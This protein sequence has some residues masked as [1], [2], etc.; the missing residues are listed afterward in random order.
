MDTRLKQIAYKKDNNEKKQTV[1]IDQHIFQFNQFFANNDFKQALRESYKIADASAHLLKTDNDLVHKLIGVACKNAN[2]DDAAHH[3]IALLLFTRCLQTIDPSVTSGISQIYFAQ[4]SLYTK[5]D[6]SFEAKT[7]M[8]NM[9]KITEG[10]LKFVTGE[11]FVE[12]LF[13]IINYFFNN[14]FHDTAN[15]LFLLATKALDDKN[16]LF[17]R[18]PFSLFFHWFLHNEVNYQSFIPFLSTTIN[19]LIPNHSDIAYHLLIRAIELSNGKDCDDLLESI[20]VQAW[21]VLFGK[22]YTDKERINR[23]NELYSISPNEYMQALAYQINNGALMF[24]AYDLKPD[25]QFI[26]S[27][28]KK[29]ADPFITFTDKTV[30][31][32]KTSEVSALSCAIYRGHSSLVTRFFKELKKDDNFKSIADQHDP[33]PLQIACEAK[34]KLDA[35]V[36]VRL[37]Q[38]DVTPLVNKTCNELCQIWSSFVAIDARVPYKIT[39]LMAYLYYFPET[40]A[41]KQSKQN[42]VSFVIQKQIENAKTSQELIELKKDMLTGQKQTSLFVTENNSLASWI[43]QP[44]PSFVTWQRLMKSIDEK[45]CDLEN[46]ERKALQHKV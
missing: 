2:L 17:N 46:A 42:Y 22:L 1:L 11:K 6:R 37:V 43:F 10:S 45:K 34:H 35:D 16:T 36:F 31:L 28:L 44:D 12:G 32:N 19:N 26:E 24:A 25:E 21:D 13:F 3:Q 38:E 41:S 30:F 33:H 9:L 20:N 18:T 27:L 4:A 14:H 39:L 15:Q 7:S 40:Q 29:G 23:I 5:M 8:E